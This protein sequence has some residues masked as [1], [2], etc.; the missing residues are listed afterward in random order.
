MTRSPSGEADEHLPLS[1]AVFHVLLALAEEPRHG[2]A[3]MKRT[4]ETSGA[5]SGPGTVYGALRRLEEKGL[6]REGRRGEPERGGKPRQLY[7][8]T[9]LG[10]RVL[11]AEAGRMARLSELA[12]ARDLLPGGEAG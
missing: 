2:Y 11:S 1:P 12:R 3:I 9:P 7:E 8:L 10:R 5:S 6:V 4:E